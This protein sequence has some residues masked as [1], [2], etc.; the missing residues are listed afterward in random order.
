MS[1]V[2]RIHCDAAD[3]GKVLAGSVLAAEAP[4]ELLCCEIWLANRDVTQGFHVRV[5]QN[6]YN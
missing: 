4:K 3:M 2:I 1:G 6:S 5:S